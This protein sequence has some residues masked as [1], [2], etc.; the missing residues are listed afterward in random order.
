[1]DTQSWLPIATLLL[2]WAL[3]L[4][5][6]WFWE[7]R[8]TKHERE[9]RRKDFQRGTIIDAQDLLGTLLRGQLEVSVMEADEYLAATVK[10][11]TL[12][13]RIEDGELGSLLS[14]ATKRIVAMNEGPDEKAKHL[15][16]EAASRAVRDFNERARVVLA[17]LY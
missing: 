7:T 10:L 2:G 12:R 3:G 9:T 6:E 4:G 14:D 5:S 15:V 17:D 13:S 8:K 16:T 11:T 1:M